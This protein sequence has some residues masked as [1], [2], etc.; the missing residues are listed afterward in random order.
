MMLL[1]TIIFNRQLR[2]FEHAKDM[3]DLSSVALH[4]RY[5]LLLLL[6]CIFLSIIVW[7]LFR[8]RSW[9][10]PERYERVTYSSEDVPD[11]KAREDLDFGHGVGLFPEFRTE[12][13]SAERGETVLDDDG[14]EPRRRWKTLMSLET[15]AVSVILFLILISIVIYLQ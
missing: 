4:N 15:L 14:L 1:S 12:N 11:L 8:P 9:A 6:T 7:K 13:E 3:P 2:F 5:L 10:L